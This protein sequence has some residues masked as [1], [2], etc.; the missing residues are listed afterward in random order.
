MFN[1]RTETERLVIRPVCS[2]DYDLFVSG[3]RNCKPAQNRFDEQFDTKVMTREWFEALIARRENEAATDYAYKFQIIEKNLACSIGYCNIYPHYREY[4]QYA[5]IG[6]AIHNNYW[7]NGYATECVS[8]LTSIGFAQIHLH[9]L[10]AHVN[11]DN[12][13]S[14]RVLLKA[15]YSYEGIR[16]AFIYEDGI[17][18]DNEVYYINNDHWKE[19]ASII[20]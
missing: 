5:H 9:R 16:K 17:W 6:Y 1:F 10:E 19:T 14:K 7:G 15:G 4:F 8:A 3:F 20:T 11:T 18:T 13:A 2:Q 12:P